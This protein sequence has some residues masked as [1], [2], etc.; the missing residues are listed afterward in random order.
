MAMKGGLGRGLGSLLGIFDEEN[1]ANA[2]NEQS[3][4]KET[5]KK[6][7]A[8]DINE[9]E[10]SLIDRNES[11]PRKNFDSASLKELADSIKQHG[12]FQPII[13]KEINGRYMI[14]AGERRFRAAKMAGLKKIPAIIKNYTDQQIKEI[15]LLENLQRE[16]LNPIETATAMRELLETYGW[17]QEILAD[18]LGKSRPVVANFLRLL[19]LCPE[20]RAMVES[21]KLSAG[22]ARSLVMVTN[23]EAQLKLAKMAV[24]KNVTVRDMEKIVKDMQNPTAKKKKYEPTLEMLDLMKLMQKKFSTKVNFMGTEKKGRIYIDYYSSDDLDR[25]YELLNRI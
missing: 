17:T 14:I 5:I 1:S 10:I 21:G 9:I 3:V 18:R 4:K 20:V 22:H 25:I 7:G 12:I 16:D 19:N 24:T 6:D 23:P 8:N 2:K 15:A 13:V 11:Q